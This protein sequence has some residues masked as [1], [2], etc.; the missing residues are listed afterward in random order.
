MEEAHTMRATNNKKERSRHLEIFKYAEEHGSQDACTYFQITPDQLKMI[1]RKVLKLRREKN[2]KYST[3]KE[4]LKFRK[5]CL[6][7]ASQSQFRNEAEDFASWAMI[8]VLEGA[9]ANVRWQLGHYRKE[10]L[11]RQDNV[12]S[13]VQQNRKEMRNTL[14]IAEPT[15]DEDPCI[16]IA[17]I[18]ERDSNY[19]FMVAT[20]IKLD[21]R[22]RVAFLL[23]YRDGMTH[24]EISR[25]LGGN[26][27]YVTTLLGKAVEKVIK[28]KEAKS[29]IFDYGLE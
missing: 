14:Q 22:T 26:A 1:R 3:P 21:L 11:G 6:Y 8:R 27:S 23:H 12:S 19:W 16:Q 7:Q 10:I 24:L 9:H 13:R 4:F 18:E 29:I 5:V 2:I 15:D 17:S 25:Y 20:E 28:N